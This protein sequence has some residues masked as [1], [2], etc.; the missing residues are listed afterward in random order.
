[1]WLIQRHVCSENLNQSY[2]HG[3][4]NTA[5]YCI[6]IFRIA[7]LGI[8][9]PV[10]QHDPVFWMKYI[11][12]YIIRISARNSVAPGYIR[13]ADTTK[14]PLRKTDLV[15]S[16][17]TRLIRETYFSEPLFL[18]ISPSATPSDGTVSG[19]GILVIH[20]S[21]QLLLIFSAPDII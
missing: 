20:P 16:V 2:F 10:T 17:T 13:T 6:Y 19:A 1:M 18:F 15:I 11:L 4:Q 5:E 21:G 12:C 8:R 3:S 9:I 7:P 14:R